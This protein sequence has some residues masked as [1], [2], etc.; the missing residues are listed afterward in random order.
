MPFHPSRHERTQL[1][2]KLS[3]PYYS[4]LLEALPASPAGGAYRSWDQVASLFHPTRRD[5]TVLDPILFV[6]LSLAQ[7]CGDARSWTILKALLLPDLWTLFK[8]RRRWDDDGEELWSALLHAF[9][10]AV[11]QFNIVARQTGLRKG[12]LNRATHRLHQ[13]YKKL[14]A[15][16]EREVGVDFQ[17]A[18][19]GAPTEEALPKA[20]PWTYAWFDPGFVYAE[21]AIDREF[22]RRNLDRHF[23]AGHLNDFELRLLL[24]S[25]VFGVPLRALARA[26]GMSYGAARQRRWRAVTRLRRHDRKSGR[27]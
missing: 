1:F 25:M 6:L 27:S 14:W 13:V 5:E 18:D 12:L 19:D 17:V 4:E 16:R 11:M 24:G 9:Y 22:L 15:Q 3:E 26:H 23:S 21:E 2:Q 7:Q 8:F 10:E 20:Q